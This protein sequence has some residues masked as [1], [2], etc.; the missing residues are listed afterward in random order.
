[1]GSLSFTRTGDLVMYCIPGAFACNHSLIMR[2]P[3]MMRYRII[4]GAV[5]AQK[6]FRY[7]IPTFV[8]WLS[9]SRLLSGYEELP[10][11]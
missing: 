2:I 11:G 9:V 10:I 3:V 4:S 6:Y 5:S 7:A 8:D 1:M